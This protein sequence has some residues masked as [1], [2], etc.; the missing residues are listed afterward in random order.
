MTSPSAASAIEIRHCVTLAEYDECVRLEHQTWSEDI[1][2]PSAMFVVAHHTGGQV[3]GAFADCKMVGF[4]LAFCGLRHGR[5]F[6]HS[7]MTAVLEGFRDRGVGRRLKLFQREDALRRSIQLIEWTF[8]PLEMKNAHFNLVRLGAIVRRY[9][10]NCYGITESPL[11]SGFPTDRLV[12]EWWLESERVRDIVADRE[13]PERKAGTAAA[14]AVR[15]S[16]PAHL[17]ELRLSDRAAA[18]R[19]QSEIREQ[20]QKWFSLGYAATSVESSA[21]RRDYVLEPSAAIGGLRL[22]ADA[23]TEDHQ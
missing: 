12:A 17:A 14:S 6:L 22:L 3:L 8:D 4:T 18:L 9:L 23:G 7:H 20:F 2:I 11:H 5:S 13:T 19:V 21:D 10:P 15:I 1:A 16:L